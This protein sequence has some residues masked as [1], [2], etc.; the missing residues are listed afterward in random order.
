MYG[1]IAPS[2]VLLLKFMQLVI[3]QLSNFQGLSSF[4]GIN[5]SNQFS[6]GRIA[7]NTLCPTSGSFIKTLKKTG[8]KMKHREPH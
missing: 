1:K 3:T 6:I 5:N 7:Q 8:P 4:D 2:Q